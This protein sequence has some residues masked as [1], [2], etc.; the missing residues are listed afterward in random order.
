M[1][2]IVVDDSQAKKVGVWQESQHT[3]PYIGD[4]YI[5]D[6]DEGKG[7]KT[8][9]FVPRLSRDGRYEVRLAYTRGQNRCEEVPVTVFSA[10]G[11]K[12]LH[13]NMRHEPPLEGRWISLG[14]FGCEAAGQN[15]VLV[16][17]DGTKGHVIADAVQYLPLE[18][19]RRRGRLPLL[20][21][22]SSQLN[23]RKLRPSVTD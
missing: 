18:D 5:H 6:R 7:E 10:D 2:G 9:S 22:Y 16:S 1:P 17:N 11:E 12:T 8:L 19:V 23:R 3:R 13:V 4:G 15:F 20:P 21:S 14:Q